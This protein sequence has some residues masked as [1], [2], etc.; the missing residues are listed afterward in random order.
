MDHNVIPVRPRRVEF[1]VGL[2]LAQLVVAATYIGWFWHPSQLS[3]AAVETFRPFLII[4]DL[5][6]AAVYLAILKAHRWALILTI[7]L[8]SAGLLMQVVAFWRGPRPDAGGLAISLFGFVVHG[9]AIA[10]LLTGVSRQWFTGVRAARQGV[11]RG[12]GLP[13]DGTWRNATPRA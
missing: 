4:G 12:D 7:G 10:L 13:V 8:L 9:T 1:A 3:S 6:F 2:L 11:N 5:A